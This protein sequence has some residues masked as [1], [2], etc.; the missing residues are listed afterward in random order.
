MARHPS[1]RFLAL[2]LLPGCG[3]ASGLPPAALPDRIEL[4]APRPGTV[5][6]SPLA[7]A[8]RARGSWYFE[9][10]FPVYLLDASG[11]TI[12]RAP[13]QAQGEWM[14]ADFVPFQVAL[15]FIPPASDH[16][17]LILAKDDPSG[18]ASL[19]AEL[20]IPVRFR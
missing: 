12:A 4:Q 10:S 2:L 1:T 11:D 15:A 7:I 17:T 8:G 3:A 9:A 5:I 18:L 13:A 6:T 14:T 16:G 20:R 19:T